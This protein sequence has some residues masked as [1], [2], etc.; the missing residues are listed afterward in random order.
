MED[1][2]AL[3]LRDL[4]WKKT[5]FEIGLNKGILTRLRVKMFGRND[6]KDKLK[7]EKKMVAL[8]EKL[9]RFDARFNLEALII[10]E[11]FRFKSSPSHYV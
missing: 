4:R 1:N 8:K 11:V 3:I 2:I 6:L 7:R 9:S 5:C 10:L